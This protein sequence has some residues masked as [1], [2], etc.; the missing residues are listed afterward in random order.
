MVKAIL[1]GR[2]TVTRRIVSPHRKAII[3]NMWFDKVDGDIVV[4]YDDNFHIGEKGYIKP[5][6]KV[7]EILY[8][9][10]TWTYGPEGTYLYRASTETYREYGHYSD[11]IWKPSIHM[12][13]EA[14]RI[15]LKVTNVRV[16]RLQDMDHDA[17]MK[18][19]IRSY[20]KDSTVYKFAPSAEWLPWRDMPRNPTEAFKLLWNSTVKKSDI[21]CYGWEANP[22]IWVIEFERV[23][24]EN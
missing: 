13:K 22:W 20:T 4:V 16:E 1:D 14:A 6:C 19:G 24:K 8:V 3:E 9:R 17:P 12:P 2:K 18:E 5:L 21:D 23:E 10:E 15:F 11:F 7:G